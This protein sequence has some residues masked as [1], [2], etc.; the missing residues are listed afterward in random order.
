L[1]S[2]YDGYEIVLSKNPP[3]SNVIALQSNKMTTVG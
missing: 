2:Y 1:E 3:T